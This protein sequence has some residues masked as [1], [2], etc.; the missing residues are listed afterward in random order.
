MI[1]Q[2][3]VIKR[4][5]IG[6]VYGYVKLYNFWKKQNLQCRISFQLRREVIIILTFY[7]YCKILL[8]ILF[9]EVFVEL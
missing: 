1:V 3:S 4:L 8:I 7:R 9:L 2:A 5:L 6:C